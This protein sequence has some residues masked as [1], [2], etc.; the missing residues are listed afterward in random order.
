VNFDKGCLRAALFRLYSRRFAQ[1]A[2]ASALDEAGSAWLP[3]IKHSRD[4][5]LTGAIASADVNFDGGCLRAALFR[6]YSRCFAQAASASALDGA[7]QA[8]LPVIKYSRDRCLTGATAETDRYLEW[9][10]SFFRRSDKPM[11]AGLLRGFLMLISEFCRSTYG[12]VFPLNCP[13]TFIRPLQTN[14]R[15]VYVKIRI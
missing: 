2:S 1:A 7:G 10:D 3:V 11:P 13:A 9:S 4:R 6:L 15:K 8:W 12:G 5:C 14:G